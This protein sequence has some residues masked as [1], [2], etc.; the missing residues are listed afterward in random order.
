VVNRPAAER[1][2]ELAAHL[3]EARRILLTTHVCADGDGLG[4]ELALARGLRQLGKQV[5][6]LNPDGLP[7]RFAFMDRDGE[8]GCWDP[9]QPL[10]QVD[11]VLVLD[12][13][14]WD[15]LG[16]MGPALRE[17]GL[18]VDFLDHHPSREDPHG[19]R[20]YGDPEATSTGELI[21]ELLHR[22]PVR[23][24]TQMAEWLYV[25]LS[26]DTNSFKYVRSQCRPLEV[27]AD[28]IRHGADTDRIYRHLFAS[29]PPGK[30]RLLG[31]L[32]AQAQWTCEGK[33]SYVEVP[34]AL[35]AEA[36]LEPEALRDVVTHLLEVRGVEIAVVFKEVR[37]GQI[38][39]SLRS[40]GAVAINGIAEELGGGGHPFASGCE[41]Q[42]EMAAVRE[43]VLGRL[44]AV[45]SRLPPS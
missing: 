19:R 9:R 37:P 1:L 39:V 32:L 8:I 38:S 24:D 15:M 33:V 35:I 5:T 30:L 4:S 12:T 16:D 13:H 23:L 29:N 36:G 2:E 45:A 40:K 34:H 28:L 7:G 18:P 10:P 41:L 20:I 43:E 6:I 42:G 21:Y 14:A 11:L 22:L 17:S 31:R 26:Y 44:C 25:S 27:A 3:R